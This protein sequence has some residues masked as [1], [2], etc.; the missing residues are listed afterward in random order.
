[1]SAELDRRLRVR[2]RFIDDGVV[3]GCPWAPRGLIELDGIRCA[4]PCNWPDCRDCDPLRERLRAVASQRFQ[5]RAKQARR[6]ILSGVR[7][8]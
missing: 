2:T 3:R 4:R 8:R 5:A 6:R 7:A 1:M